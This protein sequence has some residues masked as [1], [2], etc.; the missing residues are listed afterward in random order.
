MKRKARSP[1]LSEDLKQNPSII[2]RLLNVLT[3]DTRVALF[4]LAIKS[5][6]F[7]ESLTFQ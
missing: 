2:V 4:F 3:K 5:L 6:T 1:V 7:V